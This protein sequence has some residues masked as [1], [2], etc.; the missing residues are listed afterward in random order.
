MQEILLDAM[1]DT[2]EQ[3]LEKLEVLE[4]AFSECIVEVVSMESMAY[5][6]FM[7]SMR[8]GARACKWFIQNHGIEKSRKM[9]NAYYA[10]IVD[11]RNTTWVSNEKGA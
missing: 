5:C 6:D 8:L 9:L 7:D 4:K 10:Y 3:T 1:N 11:V 2:Q